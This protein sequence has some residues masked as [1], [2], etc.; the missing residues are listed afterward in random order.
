[1]RKKRVIFLG[2]HIMMKKDFAELVLAGIKTAT[3]RLGIVKPKKKYVLLHSGG[4][5]LAELEITGVKVKKVRE[6]V[7]EDAKQDGFESKEAFIEALKKIYGDVK[8][9]DDVT[10][11]SFNVLRRI[12][13]SEASETSR[14]LGLRPADVASIALRYGVKLHPRDLIILKKVAE[15]GSIRRAAVALFG[16]VTRRKAIRVALNK[17]IKKLIELGVIAKKDLEEGRTQG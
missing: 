6:L 11:L 8:E 12:E 1:M 3:I 2:R 16:D 17:A 13:G 4:K 7:D 10:I 14:Y 5:V 9:D 15:T